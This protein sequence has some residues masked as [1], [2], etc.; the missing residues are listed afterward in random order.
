[1]AQLGGLQ[2]IKKFVSE[3]LGKTPYFER[4]SVSTI[5][6]AIWRTFRPVAHLWAA[7]YMA[8]NTPEL[9]RAD[10]RRNP[11]LQQFLGM[12]EALRAMGEA[13]RMRQ[14]AETLLNPDATWRVPDDLFVP[15]VNI[16]WDAMPQAPG[17]GREK[18]VF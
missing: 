3:R 1:M 7:H 18:K 17:T 6:N 9:P 13:Q 14:S 12:A 15:V 5:D 2:A 10:R 11:P 8:A 16:Y 4:V